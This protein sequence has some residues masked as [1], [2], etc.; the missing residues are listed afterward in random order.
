[1][2]QDDSPE[3]ASPPHRGRILDRG[4][5]RR[6]LPA[7]FSSNLGRKRLP[8]SKAMP[9][10][11]VRSMV[12]LFE[13]SLSD[14][15]DLG[16]GRT[17]GASEAA[18]RVDDADGE[19]N[20][21][22]SLDNNNVADN[23]HR[24]LSQQS[25]PMFAIPAVSPVRV[26]YVGGYSLTLLKHKSYFNNRPLVRC[27]D[28][29]HKEDRRN[30]PKLGG[31]GR[32]SV[33]KSR[34]NQKAGAY[35]RRA[36]KFPSKRREAS[37]PIQ[38]LDDL[39][40]EIIALQGL[41]NPS[42]PDLWERRYP[43]EVEAFWGGVRSQLW[44]DEDE[45][46]AVRSESVRESAGQDT[47]EEENK[48]HDLEPSVSA[49]P[50]PDPPDPD[51]EHIFPPCPSWL[52]P[53]VPIAPRACAPSSDYSRESQRDS[54]DSS[55]EFFP[56]P[57][58]DYP[59]WDQPSPLSSPTLGAFV[60]RTPN[61]FDIHADMYPDPEL[62]ASGV[63]P[64]DRHGDP[65]PWLPILAGYSNH[66]DK[67]SRYSSGSSSSSRGTGPWIRPPTWRA[68]LFMRIPSS[69]LSLQ[70]PT[71]PASRPKRGHDRYRHRQQYNHKISTFTFATSAAA[72]TATSSSKR[73]SIGH[74]N[75][76][77]RASTAMRSTCSGSSTDLS[78]WSRPQYSAVTGRRLTTEE[79]LSELDAFL[80]SPVKRK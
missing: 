60:P 53:P 36:N 3:S 5:D 38:Q 7:S 27:L 77:R 30:I 39:M 63:I 8:P 73:S 2:D 11:S 14:L 61:I 33:T 62:P 56:G 17:Q 44:I 10:R 46:H 4:I 1:M 48:S 52:P 9:N 15:H 57:A 58:P 66:G 67:H 28:E 75:E 19:A 29:Y 40:N 71:P 64:T 47:L 24:D 12:Y 45:I 72:T 26:G 32:G 78:R 79:K 65:A 70:L 49:G 41:A 16:V 54:T 51:P 23:S 50:V 37:S 55:L 22:R 80:S 76:A 69:P 35:D 25:C 34:E 59:L 43:E 74:N 13:R 20:N 18:S 6:A 31:R 21:Y 68:P 42:S